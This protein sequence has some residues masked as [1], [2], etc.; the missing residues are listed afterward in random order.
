MSS[1]VAAY[2]AVGFPIQNL[3]MYV[4]TN[5]NVHETCDVV[6]EGPYCSS[7]G[8][9]VDDEDEQ[10]TPREGF[11]EVTETFYGLKV[12]TIPNGEGELT[13][14]CVVVSDV[15]QYSPSRIARLLSAPGELRQLYI[16][17]EEAVLS[18]APELWKPAEFGV[19]V[20]LYLS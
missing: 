1:T 4:V 13:L 10:I 5:K 12:V 8:R 16:Q 11:D 14:L 2:A 6:G 15:G 7:C 18:H 3:D 20:G 17:M 9:P 19:W